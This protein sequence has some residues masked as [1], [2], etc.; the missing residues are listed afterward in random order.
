LFEQI[1]DL[2]GQPPGSFVYHFIILSAVEAAL[3]MSAGQLMR[4]R[5]KSTARLTIA[6]TIIFVARALVLIAALLAWRYLPT[7]ILMPPIERAAD[8]MALVAL[9]WAFITMDDPAILR[10]NFMP[11][12]IA[13]SA[14]G[15][16]VAGF[17]G[18]YYYW[19]FAASR[20]QLFNGQWLDYAWS[21]AQIL[22]AVVGLFWM[23]FRIRYAYD[24][25]L[26]GIMLIFLGTAAG[27]QI[28]QP[29]L[30]D[31]AAAVRIGQIIVMPMLAAVTY[32]HVVEQLLH[33]DEFE[34]SRL[35]LPPVPL[36]IG[37]PSTAPGAEKAPV[38]EKPAAAAP[39]P[40][41]ESL[42]ETVRAQEPSKQPKD[43]LLQPALL[44]VVD[45]MGGL[46]S[47]GTEPDCQEA[48][49]AIAM[50]CAQTWQCWQLSMK[51]GSR[52]ASWGDM[53]I[54][55]RLRCRRRCSTSLTT[56]AS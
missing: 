7:N 44:E 6:I 4:E 13:A 56:P 39:P 23:L 9:A 42:Q 37:E 18:T 25:F 52:Q 48:P 51:S 31:V 46:L 2:V 12:L 22:V 17:V 20:G 53:T 26:K 11:D 5:D 28:V 38:A 36:H 55:P 33:Y 49:R 40:P 29:V 19:F 34:P 47:T 27:I 21:G 32:R 16:V 24:P 3:A 14:L 10:R 50:R 41:P 1:L 35:S 43:K 45:A 8:T 54:L 30:G 15:A